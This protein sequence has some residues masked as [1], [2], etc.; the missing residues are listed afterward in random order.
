MMVREVTVG[1]CLRRRKNKQREHI[2]KI[3]KCELKEFLIFLTR[4][5]SFHSSL[6]FLFPNFNFQYWKSSVWVADR[7]QNMIAFSGSPLSYHPPDSFLT[8][9]SLC[10]GQFLLWD[11]NGLTDWVAFWILSKFKLFRGLYGFLLGTFFPI[12]TVRLGI[13]VLNSK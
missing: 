6:V 1:R 10:A 11:W 5:K 9:H 8:L 4:N 13:T 2:V 3:L 7:K 12:Q